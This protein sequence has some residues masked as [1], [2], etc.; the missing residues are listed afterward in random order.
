M[1]NG[2]RLLN[3]ETSQPDMGNPIKELIG[4]ASSRLPNSASL[5]SKFVLIEGI[6]DAQEA[7]QNPSKKKKTLKDI[8]WADL[9][10]IE[11]I[12]QCKYLTYFGIIK[13]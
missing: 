7:K 6:R 4:M 5:K 3:L 10:F 2:I 8:R 13:G 1:N 11:L 12:Y 9:W